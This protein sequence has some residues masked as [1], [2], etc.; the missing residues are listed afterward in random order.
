MAD[1]PNTPAN[2]AWLVWGGAI[3]A[4]LVAILVLAVS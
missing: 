2:Q 4:A 1:E 3:L